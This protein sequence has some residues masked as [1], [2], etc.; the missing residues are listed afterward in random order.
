M[1]KNQQIVIFTPEEA[2]DRAETELKEIIKEAT[3]EAHTLAPRRTGRLKA[4]VQGRFLRGEQGM[5]GSI[6]AA[7][8]PGLWKEYGTRKLS[9]KPF[10]RPS[11]DVDEVT[12][13]IADAIVKGL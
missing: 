11:V 10:L 9:P 1:A 2:F 6:S 8:A 5:I 3:N 12:N 4:S 7:I 13:R